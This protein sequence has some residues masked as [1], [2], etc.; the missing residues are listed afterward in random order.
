[1]ESQR[2]VFIYTVFDL[3]SLLF[4]VPGCYIYGSA[5]NRVLRYEESK[6]QDMSYSYESK[7]IT[8]DGSFN[9]KT[10]F[11]EYLDKNPTV[12][13]LYLVDADDLT[14]RQ[15]NDLLIA[16]KSRCMVY[17]FSHKFVGSSGKYTTTYS[18]L[19][20]HEDK[21]TTRR[22]SFSCPCGTYD[23]EIVRDIRPSKISKRIGIHGTN[24]YTIC[25]ANCNDRQKA[26]IEDLDELDG[27]E[28]TKFLDYLKLQR[29]EG[30]EVTHL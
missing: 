30:E 2:F 18:N 13:H 9:S 16:S 12:E 25:N 10:D 17:I 7:N 5:G 21:I 1:M 24:W 22:I 3:V 28:F 29:S 6:I 4:N 14:E 19:E 26:T 20:K 15:I 8:V 23:V 11:S 27:A